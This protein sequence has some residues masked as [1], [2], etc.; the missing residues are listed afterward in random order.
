M[1]TSL[2]DIVLTIAEWPT[3][4]LYVLSLIAG[5]I[6]Y[7]LPM[8]PGDTAVV[9]LG[10]I[11]PHSPHSAW[12]IWV[13]TTLASTVGGI[14]SFGFGV[15]LEQTDRFAG[16]KKRHRGAIRTVVKRFEKHGAIYLSINRFIPGLRTF[17][18]IAAAFAKLRFYQVL[19]WGFVSSAAWMGLLVGVAVALSANL[20]RL[21]AGMGTVNL[22]LIGVALAIAAWVVVV[23][24]RGNSD[25][26]TDESEDETLS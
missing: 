7:I 17:F 8:L 13:L 12:T 18:F 14:C 9:A 1:P 22:I 15:W 16:F 20:Q 5:F 23:L 6:E 21:E 3:S 25:S 24:V 11:A 26:S 4:L 10:A 19:L 2:S